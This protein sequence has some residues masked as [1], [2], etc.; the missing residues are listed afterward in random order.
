MW[1]AYDS[2]GDRAKQ[3]TMFRASRDHR[4]LDQTVKGSK[5]GLKVKLILAERSH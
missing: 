4:E 2:P 1:V 3:L 5:W